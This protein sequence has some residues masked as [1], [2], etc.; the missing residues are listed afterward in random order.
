[1]KDNKNREVK[2]TLCCNG[3]FSPPTDENSFI[4]SEDKTYLIEQAY[5]A[6]RANYGRFIEI[7]KNASALPALAEIFSCQTYEAIG[8]ELDSLEIE[9]KFFLF[10]SIIA[11][12]NWVSMDNAP[13]GLIPLYSTITKNYLLVSFFS[14]RGQTC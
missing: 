5:M 8:F 10:E 6:G 11:A 4:S 9:G 3:I 2:M 7:C 12:E 1:M 13:K 14:E